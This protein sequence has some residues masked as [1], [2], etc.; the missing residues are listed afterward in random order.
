MFQL[1][2]LGLS[3]LAQAGA[4]IGVAAGLAARN[5]SGFA[6][7]HVS[8]PLSQGGGCV[9]QLPA[10]A[11]LAVR[12]AEVEALC[13]EAMPPGLTAEVMAGAGFLHVELLKTARL[14]EPDL[15]VLGG[16]DA[17]ERCRR[18]LSASGEHA[19]LLVAAQ[20]PCPVLVAPSVA[21]A[22]QGGF[23]SV[24]AATDLSGDAEAL[25]GLAGLLALSEGAA[26]RAF[27]V[28]PLPLETPL[29]EP[30]ALARQLETARDRLAY[31]CH[32][33]P[34]RA[35]CRAREG[36]P[37]LEI[38]KETREAEAD[39]LV[40]ATD[41]YHTGLAPGS[42]VATRVLEGA[43]CPVLLVGAQALAKIRRPGLAAARG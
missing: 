26:L 7:Q 38:L 4:A 23:R 36:D 33:L 15:I 29:P 10:E 18:E 5:G 34:G 40:L 13:R 28:L 39:L 21:Q 19:A 16:Q 9:L 2:L 12:R 25:L 3:D 17:S 6:V 22:R 32:D 41:I 27:T 30:E 31:L 43:R 14:L 42:P 24:V 35:D 37:A 20:A 8:A 1:V 11:D